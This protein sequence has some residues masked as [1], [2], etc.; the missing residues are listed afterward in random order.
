MSKDRLPQP[1]QK[2]LETELLSELF[3]NGA[4]HIPGL[5]RK[6][7]K[8]KINLHEKHVSDVLIRCSRPFF[9]ENTY[10]R[11]EIMCIVDRTGLFLYGPTSFA[12]CVI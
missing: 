7:A 11:C 5:L 8:E 2:R 10:R 1:V 9:D 3:W 12:V 4:V 6:L